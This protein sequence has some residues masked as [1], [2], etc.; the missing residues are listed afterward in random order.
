[1]GPLSAY[2]FACVQKEHPRWGG[3]EG[4]EGYC[5]ADT[6]QFHVNP[7]GIHWLNRPCRKWEVE[8]DN[9]RYTICS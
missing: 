1:M 9:K 6:K 8:K 2:Y 5:T 4:R 7:Q 3:K